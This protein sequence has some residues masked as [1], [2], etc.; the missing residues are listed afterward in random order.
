VEVQDSRAR[1]TEAQVTNAEE[2]NGTCTTAPSS[3]ARTRLHLR[4]AHG[5]RDFDRLLD[6]V[7]VGIEE[8]QT[9]VVELRELANGLH[10]QRSAAEASLQL[11]TNSPPA[12]RC[13]SPSTAPTCGLPH[14]R[15][16]CLFIACE[17][18]TNAVKHA[19]PTEIFIVLTPH[20]TTFTLDITDD[21][22]GGATPTDTACAASPTA[23]KPSAG[24]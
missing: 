5:S 11:W 10:P 16:H 20:T 17:A 12:H 1:L 3:A 13:R 7:D 23:R 9:A 22:H 6:A 18:L 8:L 15:G 4:S 19:D 14:D 2:S 24:P 21:G